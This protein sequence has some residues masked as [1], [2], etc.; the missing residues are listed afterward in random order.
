M[1]KF[2]T[3]ITRIVISYGKLLL[4]IIALSSTGASTKA[5]EAYTYLN[6]GIEY[7]R[8]SGIY[9]KSNYNIR[10]KKFLD[11]YRIIEYG[12]KWIKATA[13][14]NT[15]W[16]NRDTGEMS[17]GRSSDSRK[18]PCK[19]IYYTELPQIDDEGKQF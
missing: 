16:L 13:G 7:L 17:Y 3:N 15:I 2:I 8:L 14:Y 1:K 12:E 6:C 5:D 11:S 19:V 4:M 10:T 18:Y 9:I